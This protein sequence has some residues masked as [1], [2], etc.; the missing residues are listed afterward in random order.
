MTE[1][2]EILIEQTAKWLGAQLE[3]SVDEW[4]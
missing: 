3:C 1:G 4:P 2:G